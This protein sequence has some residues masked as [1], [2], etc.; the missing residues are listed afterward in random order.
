MRTGFLVMYAEEKGGLSS[1]NRGVFLNE[2]DAKEAAKGYG[3]W[4]S[5]GKVVPIPIFDS[6]NEF[7]ENQ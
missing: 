2:N 3:W 1:K 4:G 7:V 5:D 6:Y